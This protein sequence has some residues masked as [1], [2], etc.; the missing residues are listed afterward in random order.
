MSKKEA[1]DIKGLVEKEV[2]KKDLKERQRQSAKVARW[3]EEERQKQERIEEMKNDTFANITTSNYPD[4]TNLALD[5]G[6]GIICD[7]DVTISGTNYKTI[8]ITVSYS[9]RGRQYQELIT[10]IISP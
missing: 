7:R 8:T 9:Y 2:L 1:L 3:K 10:T 4:E 6:I 5:S